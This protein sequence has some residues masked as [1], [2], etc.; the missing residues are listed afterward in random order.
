MRSLTSN[1]PSTTSRQRNSLSR[2]L[3][4]AAVQD[5]ELREGRATRL[6]TASLWK[7]CQPTPG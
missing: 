2:A 7:I 3:V 6:T 5:L 4:E 1:M